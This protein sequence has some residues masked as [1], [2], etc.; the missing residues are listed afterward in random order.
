MHVL[1][2]GTG[3]ATG[4]SLRSGSKLGPDVQLLKKTREMNGPV[5]PILPHALCNA[6][7]NREYSQQ[8]QNGKREDCHEH[9]TCD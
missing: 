7:S 5:Q 2:P 9:I 4:Q 1:P 8:R 3:W 6:G